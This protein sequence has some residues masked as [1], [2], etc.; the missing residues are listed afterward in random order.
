MGFFYRFP[1]VFLVPAFS[2]LQE[3][4]E[5]PTTVFVKNPPPFPRDESLEEGEPPAP[6]VSDSKQDPTFKTIDLSSDEDVGLEADLE[7]EDMWPQDLESM[8]ESKAD[9]LKRSSMKRVKP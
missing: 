6:S 1:E 9:K 3:E 5:I 7:E 2:L 8:E 4:N